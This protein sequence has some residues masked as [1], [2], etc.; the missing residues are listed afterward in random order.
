[1]LPT[2]IRPRVNISCLGTVVDRAV[3]PFGIRE[4]TV[5]AEHLLRINGESY[6]LKGACVHK[7]NGPLELGGNRPERR[8]GGFSC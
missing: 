2:A 6:K 7:D 4:V 5:D 8:I 3:T 1:M